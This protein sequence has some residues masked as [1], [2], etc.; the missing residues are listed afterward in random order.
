MRFMIFLCL[1]SRQDMSSWHNINPANIAIFGFVKPKNKGHAMY[2]A[3]KGWLERCFHD[4]EAV[5]LAWLLLLFTL[6]IVF[7]GHILAPMLGSIVV[8]FLLDWMAQGLERH[9]F[10][11]KFAVG[12]V[13]LGFVAMVVLSCVWLIPILLGQTKNLFHDLPNLAAHGQRELAQFLERFPDLFSQAQL[14][15]LSASISSGLNE[16]AKFLLTA[17]LSSIPGVLTVIIYIVLIPILVFLLLKDK[18][19]LIDWCLE[20]LPKR[21]PLLNRVANE[22]N[23]QLGNYIRGKFVEFFVVVIA[24][25]LGFVIFHLNYALLLAIG[26]GLSVFVP[27]IGGIVSTIPVLIVA[28]LQFDFGA[29]FG[30]TLL[31]YSVIQ[32]L[33]ANVLV[34]ILFSGAVKMHAVAILTAVLLFGGLFGFWGVFFAIPLAVLVKAVLGSWPGR[35]P[36]TKS[37]KQI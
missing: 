33:D 2:L 30:W 27:F 24:T 29:T 19:E 36:K 21:R 32:L 1:Q 37:Q 34:P 8:A 9:G 16:S 17:S 7:L 18:Q 22:V 15:E 31:V 10:S 12:V 5:L 28:Y 23:A 25:Y 6:V 13:F 14:D 11:R 20:Y 3:L 26:V 4:E 35:P